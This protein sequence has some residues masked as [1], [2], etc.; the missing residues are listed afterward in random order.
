MS[1][2]ASCRLLGEGAEE[3]DALVDAVAPLPLGHL[4]FVPSKA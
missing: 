2:R 4:T 1:R 3:Y